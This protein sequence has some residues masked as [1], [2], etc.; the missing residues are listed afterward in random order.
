MLKQTGVNWIQRSRPTTAH[1]PRQSK[2]WAARPQSAIHTVTPT[3]LFVHYLTTQNKKKQIPVDAPSKVWVC[4]HSLGGIAASNSA[5][6]MD[7]HLLYVVLS[8]RGL[9]DGL[10]TSPEESYRMWCVVVCDLEISWIRR[11]WPTGVC[12]AIV[13]RN[14]KRSSNGQ[15]I[16]D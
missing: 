3:R 16:S 7:M 8:S 4:G 2:L 9:C 6:G 11:S 1:Q 5:G 15:K 14:R 12:R 10:I 13:N